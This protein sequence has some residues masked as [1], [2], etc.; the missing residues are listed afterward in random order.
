M[1]RSA[2]RTT[3]CKAAAIALLALFGP[4]PAVQAMTVQPVVVDLKPGGKDQSATISVLNTFTT[5]LPVELTVE[6]LTFDESGA[7]PGAPDKTDLLL[8]PPQALIPPGQTQSFRIQWVGDPE[9]ATS[10][11][12]YVT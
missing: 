9:L 12:Y 10:R 4:P 1:Q 11:H 2:M 6:T 3:F 7:H 5:P 8:F